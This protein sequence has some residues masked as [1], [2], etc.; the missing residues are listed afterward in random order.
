MENL[1]ADYSEEEIIIYAGFWRR[2]AAQLIDGL[3]LGILVFPLT[4]YDL[5]VWKN[6]PLYII[7]SILSALYKP[8]MEYKYGATWGKMA[9]SVRCVNADYEK[10]S[11]SQAFGRNMVFLVPGILMVI[12]NYFIF[13]SSGFAQANTFIEVGQCINQFSALSW[14]NNLYGLFLLV[15]AIVLGTDGRK[16]SLHDKWANTYVIKS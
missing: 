5:I 15:D 12:L 8:L 7:T 4:W 11:L 3:L 1:A 13:A 16:R 10:L 6:Y 14:T 9:M 2:F